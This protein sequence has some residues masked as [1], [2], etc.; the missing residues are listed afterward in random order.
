MA[1]HRLNRGDQHGYA[2]L[3]RYLPG[4]EPNAVAS[5]VPRGARGIEITAP[6]SHTGLEDRLRDIQ[7]ITDAALSRLDGRA[8]LAEL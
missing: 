2:T 6:V 7:A 3:N 4:L 1:E 8:L 5:T